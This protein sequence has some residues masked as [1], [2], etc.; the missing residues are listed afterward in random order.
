MPEPAGRV[1]PALASA[2]RFR[3]AFTS[4]STS[5]PQVLQVYSRSDRG[6]LA[7][8][9]PQSEHVLLDG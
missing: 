2:A 4:R 6:S 9:A 7:F 3:A 8:T 5:R 1:S